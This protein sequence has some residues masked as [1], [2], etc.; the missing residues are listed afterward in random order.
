MLN[1]LLNL[2]SF[3]LRKYKSKKISFS[4]TSIDLLIS[5]IFRNKRKGIFIDIGCNHPVYNNNTY[6]L[7][8]KGWRGINIDLDEKSINLFNTFRK[9]DLNIKQA[10]SSK[11]EEVDLYFYHNKSPINTINKDLVNFHKTKPK[12]IKKIN[13]KTLNS[14]IMKTPFANEKIDFMNIDVEGHELNVLKGFDLKKYSPTIIVIEYL[15]LNVKKLEIT[16]FNLQNIINS[17][18]YKYMI[19]NNYTLVNWIHSDLVF[20]NNNY[21]D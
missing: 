14:I 20:V 21:R 5:Y 10:I 4:L 2:P 19:N 1:Y 17:E 18:V 3:L 6:L 13:T 9:S 7:Y 12:Q 8:K 11:A 15:D 16:N